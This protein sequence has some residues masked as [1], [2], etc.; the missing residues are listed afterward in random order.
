MYVDKPW[1]VLEFEWDEGNSHK[2]WQKHGVFRKDAEEVFLDPDLTVFPDLKHS[3]KE[4][5]LVVVGK[6]IEGSHL[7]IVFTIRKRRLRVISARKMH[8]E[9]VEKYEKVKKSS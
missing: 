6:N 9:E 3:V 8:N 5:R 7:F 2:S 4:K 1:E